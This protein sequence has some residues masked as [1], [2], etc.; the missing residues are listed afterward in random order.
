[1]TNITLADH[2][3][4]AKEALDAAEKLVRDL[5]RE[6]LATGCETVEGDLAIISVALSERK[7]LDSVAVKAFLTADQIEACTKVSLVETL[8]IKPRIIDNLKIA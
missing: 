1:M 5:R 4:A 6:I 2:Y 7:T 3:A 8:R